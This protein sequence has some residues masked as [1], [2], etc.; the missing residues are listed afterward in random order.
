MFSFWNFADL[1]KLMRTDFH[2]NW[3]TYE[4][5]HVCNSMFYFTVA[6]NSRLVFLL[7]PIFFFKIKK[8]ISWM[9][10]S[11]LTAFFH[12]PVFQTKFSLDLLKSSSFQM[13]ICGWTKKINLKNLPY[14][15]RTLT[16]GTPSPK[17]L[18]LIFEILQILIHK[19][20][21]YFHETS[22]TYE[23]HWNSMSHFTMT[24]NS[25]I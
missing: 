4:W 10:P 16:T 23:W 5:L 24:D 25:L 20:K 17:Y 22:Y 19:W 21:Y 7:S 6:D 1:D 12:L 18:M 13:L 14:K 15:S 8:F 3:H 2:E 11:P 9:L